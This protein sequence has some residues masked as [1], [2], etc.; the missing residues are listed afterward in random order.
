[1]SVYDQKI[2]RLRVFVNLQ[3]GVD[4][5]Y[6]HGA[7]VSCPDGWNDMCAIKTHFVSVEELRNL[8]YLLGRAIAHAEEAWA[9][10]K[11]K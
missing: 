3:G 10:D 8:H 5:S 6:A 9:I 2:G 11:R 7:E 1:M 4:H